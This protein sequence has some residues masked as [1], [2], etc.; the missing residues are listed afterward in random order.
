MKPLR[1]LL[2]TSALAVASLAATAAP[3]MAIVGGHATTNGA[4]PA[5]AEITFGKSFLC[6]GTLIAPTTCSPPATAARSP[7]PP[8]RRP[9]PGPRR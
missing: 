2:L 5:V 4:Y 7:A 9:H 1:R 3:S 8:S 6:T